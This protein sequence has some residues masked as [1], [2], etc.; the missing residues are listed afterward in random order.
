M[1]GLSR[2]IDRDAAALVKR[3]IREPRRSPIDGR[4]VAL[5]AWLGAGFALAQFPVRM[6]V[7]ICRGLAATI[8]TRRVK[9]SRRTAIR[10]GGMAPEGAARVVTSLYAG[11]LAAQLDLLR[12]L[13]RG[14][15]LTIETE[16]L[17]R[18]A[19]AIA[20]GHGAVLWISDLAGAA[21]VAKIALASAGHGV[22]HLSRVEHGFSKSR[23]GIRFLNPLRLAFER[24]YLEE[25]VVFDRMNPAPAMTRLIGWLRGNGIVSIVAGAHEGGRLAEVP[26]LA[27]RL[28]LALGAPRL[29]RLTGAPVIPVFALRDPARPERF[30]VTFGPPLVAPRSRDAE[31]DL[32]AT[33]RDYAARLEAFVRRYPETWVGWRRTGQLLS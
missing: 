9:E 12:D 29:A 11:R 26:F 17:G 33:A 13:T 25:R 7:G 1:D 5:A 31:A 8:R 20:D 22:K 4:D 23:F 27:G 30:T 18:V 32:L 15:D 16:G 28:R 14:S 6:R 3:P 19:A 21:D 2:D 24:R 10:I